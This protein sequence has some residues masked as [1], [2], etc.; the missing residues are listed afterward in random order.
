M[1]SSKD[2]FVI[3]MIVNV[4]MLTILN[5]NV[6]K[7]LLLDENVNI[8]SLEENVINFFLPKCQYVPLDQKC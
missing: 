1:K 2:E 7:I 8:F 5:K 3:K 6:T 4:I